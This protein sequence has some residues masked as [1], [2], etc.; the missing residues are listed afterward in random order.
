MLS[1]CS[2]V[3]ISTN[4]RL[5]LLLQVQIK[6]KKAALA[7][8]L[9]VLNFGFRIAGAL[10]ISPFLF[11]GLFKAFARTILVDV[12]LHTAEELQFYPVYKVS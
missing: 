2:G 7:Q 8:A 5:C 6:C 1:I 3:A 9:F 4:L 12:S 11:G 10:M